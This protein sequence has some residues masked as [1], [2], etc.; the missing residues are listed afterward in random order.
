MNFIATKCVFSACSCYLRTERITTADLNTRGNVVTYTSSSGEVILQIYSHPY[1]DLFS[2]FKRKKKMKKK[3]VQTGTNV[4]HREKKVQ[5]FWRR[6]VFSFLVFFLFI[7]FFFLKLRNFFN[8]S[9]PSFSFLSA[10]VQMPS[11]CALCSRLS[12]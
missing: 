3:H 5:I 1:L 11:L 9:A 10:S 8:F 12:F 7:F 2:H 4:K 6:F